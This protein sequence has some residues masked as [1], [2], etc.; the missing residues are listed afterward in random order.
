MNKKYILIIIL[1]VVVA[2]FSYYRFSRNGNNKSV[3]ISTTSQTP[4]ETTLSS[5]T[6]TDKED[7]AKALVYG[8]EL[9]RS[10]NMS[11]IR[12]YLVTSK[13]DKKFDT[14]PDSAIKSL[15]TF[16]V[17]NK[18]NFTQEEIATSKTWD[19]NGNRVYVLVER[20]STTSRLEAIKVG[21]KWY[22]Y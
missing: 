10:G 5:I 18:E 20:G 19:F 9:F 1:I 3:D 16:L 22:R 11:A 7:I 6:N 2:G 21:N 8:R 12:E 14:L 15:S 17:S 13:P 4:S